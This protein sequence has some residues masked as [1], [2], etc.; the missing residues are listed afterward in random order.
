MSIATNPTL[1]ARKVALTAHQLATDYCLEWGDDLWDTERRWQEIL[2]GELARL[3]LD[4]AID[5][6]QNEIIS[7]GEYDVIEARILQALR[8]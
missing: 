1:C 2:G 4:D 3:S 6:D 8:R 5:L 7:A